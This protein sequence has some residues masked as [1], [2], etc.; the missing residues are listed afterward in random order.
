MATATTRAAGGAFRVGGLVTANSSDCYVTD[1]LVL[2]RY[3]AGYGF[4][5]LLL[6]AATATAKLDAADGFR[7]YAPLSNL[8]PVPTTE[9]I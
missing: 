1:R 8:T 4:R 3:P 5:V 6:D 2:R 9:S 7:V